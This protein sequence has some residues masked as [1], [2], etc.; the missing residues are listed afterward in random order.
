MFALL[1][2]I[3]VVEIQPSGPKTT[4]TVPQQLVGEVDEKLLKTVRREV[5][6]AED[7]QDRVE[8]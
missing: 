7:V 4:P 2:R 8:H 3:A 5:L 1:R 6:E